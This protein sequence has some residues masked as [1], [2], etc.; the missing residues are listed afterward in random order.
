MSP[1]DVA[2]TVS[3]ATAAVRSRLVGRPA[4]A[5]A[6]LCLSLVATVATARWVAATNR[7]LAIEHA[8]P[9]YDGRLG[10][11]FVTCGAVLLG[12]AALA[13]YADAGLAPSVALA[14]GPVFGWAVNAFSAPVTPA[15]AVTFP[16]EM[17]L[18]Y[19]GVFGLLG[20]LLGN[21]MRRAVPPSLARRF[22]P[23]ALSSL[24]MSAVLFVLGA[25]SA[26]AANSGRRPRRRATGEHPDG[27]D[28]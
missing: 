2:S 22:L 3:A 26:S 14:G 25:R 16:V 15:Y 4:S 7:Y 23:A 10:P 19:G 28:R 13:A 6:A 17:A 20:Y 12:L 27:R 18:L 5:L 9:T 21:G 11:L 24:A 8:L 1:L